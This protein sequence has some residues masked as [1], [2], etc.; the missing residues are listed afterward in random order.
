MIIAV[1][2]GGTK[3]LLAVFDDQGN[4]KETIKFPTN[5]EFVE[6]EKDLALNAAKLTIKQFTSGAVALRCNIDRDKGILISD[7]VL[8]WKNAPVEA[9]CQQI[10]NCQ[11]QVENDTKLA[12]LSEA[13]L[14]PNFNKVMYVTISTGIGT[15]LIVGER[16][17]VDTNDSEF[18]KSIYP[19]GGR[20]QK[21]ESFASGQ[22]MV[23]RYGKKAEDIDD[24]TIWDEISDDWAMGIINACL[25]YRP[26]V[27]VI[28]GS[29]GTHFAKYK[30]FLEEAIEDLRPREILMPPVR[31]AVHPE[32]AVVYGCYELAKNN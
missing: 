5:K 7:D 13:I 9:K 28:G 2:I 6:F 30:E 31:Q 22:A 3:T 18:G 32:E 10:F 12:G 16:I 21:W 19:H 27:V 17:D 14:L 25:A 8:R 23:T 1:D 29:V 24:P 11:F 20:Y 15:A 4:I 26:D